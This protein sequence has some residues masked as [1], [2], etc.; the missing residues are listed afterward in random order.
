MSGQGTSG[1]RSRPTK[2][3][4][5]KDGGKR[6]SKVLAAAGVASRR[7]CEE[8]IFSGKVTVNGQTMLLPQTLV[9]D[10]DAIAV[11][12][13]Q[14][15]G[16]SAKA[17]Y[18]LNKPVGCVCSQARRGSERL[19][20]DLFQGTSERLFTVGRLDKD[21]GGLILVTNDGDFANAVIH[22]SKKIFKEYL[23]KANADITHDHLVALAAGTLVDGGKIKPHTVKKVRKNTL[24]IV[25]SEGRK[26][27]VRLL[28]QAVGLRVIELTRIRIGG[29]VLGKLSPGT[30]RT[31][32]ERER[33]AL[34][35]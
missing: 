13:Q 11:D 19:V 5:S 20:L 10:G 17:Y 2:E 7:A 35:G 4:A 24:K 18:A 1:K 28:L 3:K 26:H 34:F 16:E 9:Q 31:L 29:L 33:N 8:L 23:V 12:G 30:Y 27:E 22:P 32:S 25:I 6:L 21:T 14:I 15:G